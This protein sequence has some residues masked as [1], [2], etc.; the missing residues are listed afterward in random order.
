[1]KSNET[2]YK[3]SRNVL[4]VGVMCMFSRGQ[5]YMST[6]LAAS[7]KPASQHDSENI[8]KMY[9]KRCKPM[10]EKKTSVNSADVKYENVLKTVLKT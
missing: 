9:Q 10:F 3:W 7:P 5:K 4:L 2:S 1:M 8:L 6:Q